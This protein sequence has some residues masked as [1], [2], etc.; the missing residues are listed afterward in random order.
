MEPGYRP[1][2]QESALVVSL[3]MFNLMVER[4]VQLLKEHVASPEPP[5]PY[6]VPSDCLALLPAIKVSSISINTRGSA[7][8]ETRNI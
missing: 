3:Q 8:G 5:S 7:R 6:I 2:L 4:F 1:A